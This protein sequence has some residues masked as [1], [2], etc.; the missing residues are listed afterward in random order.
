MQR[1]EVRHARDRSRPPPSRR[2]CTNRCFERPQY[3]CLCMIGGQ[4]GRP[5]PTLGGMADKQGFY[6]DLEQCGWV[7]SP[8]SEP[9]VDVPEQQT[10]VE[11]AEEADVQAG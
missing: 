5:R 11:T 4:V 6:W 10:A 1:E 7:R 3:D 8:A 9:R 2:S